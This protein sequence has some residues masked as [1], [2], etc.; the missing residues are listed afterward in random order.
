MDVVIHFTLVTCFFVSFFL[1]Q[2]PPFI[3][4]NSEQISVNSSLVQAS[5]R[6]TIHGHAAHKSRNDE[7]KPGNAPFNKEEKI[8]VYYT[9]FL[10]DLLDMIQ[11]EYAKMFSGEA[12]PE[13]TVG[14]ST[15]FDPR[16]SGSM[17]SSSSSEG[18]NVGGFGAKVMPKIGSTATEGDDGDQDKDFK[19]I[20]RE[21]KDCKC[22]IAL[23]PM[24]PTPERLMAVR[25]NEPFF[26]TVSLS[27][28]MKKPILQ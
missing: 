21:V 24:T 5:P 13:Y 7:Y 10:I 20:V 9:G 4:V 27:I 8:S 12:F 11:E 25:F 22:K 28:L 6:S 17:D 19:G 1:S 2:H 16:A 15:Y 18:G 23:M 26:D 3:F 14:M